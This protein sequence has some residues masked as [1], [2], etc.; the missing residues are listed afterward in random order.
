MAEIAHLTD[1]NF[2]DEV[3]EA[4]VPVLVDFWAAW[5]G[6]CRAMEPILEE[7]AEEHA[8]SIKIAK[9][10]VDDNRKTA[11]TYEVLSIPTF[12]VF[13]SGQVK[14]K[15]IGSMPKNKM[16]EELTHWIK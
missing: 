10:N 4:K 8:E 7:L 15:L 2:K 16:I 14:K 12:I 9:V 6:P 11:E 13:E 3:L 5:C 1:D